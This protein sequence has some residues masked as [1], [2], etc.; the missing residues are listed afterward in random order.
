MYEEYMQNLLGRQQNQNMYD[1]NAMQNYQYNGY[2]Y[3]MPNY[4]YR[5]N[6]IDYGDY[7]YGGNYGDMQNGCM[8]GYRQP[9]NYF[10]QTR[11]VIQNLSN[12]EIE[13]MYPDIYRIVYPMVQKRCATNTKPITEETL[14]EM[15]REIYS[16]IEAENIINIDVTVDDSTFENNRGQSNSISDEKR[17]DESRSSNLKNNENVL[18]KEV[19]AENRQFRNNTLRDLIRILLI[20]E[21]V[22]RP[23][24]W[25]P[26]P[27]MPPRPPRPR[28]PRPRGMN[29]MSEP[30][31]YQNNNF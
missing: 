17:T 19:R 25:R 9:M 20:R 5:A 23:R 13:D 8:C 27:P 14:D 26:R 11:D 21:L 6:D 1:N 12:E 7:M 16:N 28:P 2:D 4:Q 30:N 31:V 29:Y 18:K 15:T 22:G 3:G 24:N 10:N